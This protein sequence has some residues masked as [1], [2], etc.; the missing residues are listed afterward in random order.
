MSEIDLS[1]LTL[2][3]LTQLQCDIRKERERRRQEG[4]RENLPFVVGTAMHQAQLQQL[5]REAYPRKH[6]DTVEEAFE[7]MNARRIEG[8]GEWK[9]DPELR[10]VTNEDYYPDYPIYLDGLTTPA[11]L[12]DTLL[13][14]TTKGYWA[15]D[16]LGELVGL[17]KIICLEIF[18]NSIQGIFCPNG[19]SRTVQWLS[20]HENTEG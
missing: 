4:L 19:E 15:Y 17:L 8:I 14:I 13:Q 10:V 2:S 3:Q 1:Q 16:S 6:W 5:E 18:Q 7:G 12:L 20:T 11:R 9:Y